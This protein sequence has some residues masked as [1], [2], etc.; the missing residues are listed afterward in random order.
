MA[1]NCQAAQVWISRQRWWP[2]HASWQRSHGKGPHHQTLLFYS[3][4]VC[5]LPCMLTLLPMELI[6]KNMFVFWHALGKP[7]KLIPL[8]KYMIPQKFGNFIAMLRLWVDCRCLSHVF[9]MFWLR[10]MEF[11][12][13]A[14]RLRG[15]AK[16]LD[17]WRMETKIEVQNDWLLFIAG[18]NAPNH[19]MSWNHHLGKIFVFASTN[20]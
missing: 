14:Q 11:I 6:D 16:A 13:G 9:Y 3:V 8:K 7:C 17:I 4:C 15:G 10:L 19:E 1:W 5:V 2:D 12:E 20:I 18:Q